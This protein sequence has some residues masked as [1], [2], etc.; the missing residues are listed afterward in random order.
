M[1][2]ALDSISAKSNVLQTTPLV[3]NKHTF[4]ARLDGCRYCFSDG[5]VA[6]FLGGIYEFDPDNIPSDYIPPEGKGTVEEC[7]ARRLKELI[8][9][10]TVPNPVFSL[11]PVEIHRSDAKV[12]R[13]IGSPGGSIAASGV[14]LVGS[15]H[16]AGNLQSSV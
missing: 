12:L 9:V 14:G 1:N 10:C 4:Y 16:V 15:F 5:G 8:Y 3:S 13:E 6:M 2:N 7:W 11:T